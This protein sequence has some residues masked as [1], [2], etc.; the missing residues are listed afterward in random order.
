MDCR[1]VTEVE[2][3]GPAHGLGM[4]GEGPDLDQLLSPGVLT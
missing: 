4:G 1:R 2:L 3:I